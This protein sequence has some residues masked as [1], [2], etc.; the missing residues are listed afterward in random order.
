[1]QSLQ[2]SPP[3][4][5]LWSRGRRG[6]TLGLVL[7][8][9]MGALESL[10]VATIMPVVVREIGGRARKALVRPHFNSQPC[11]AARWAREEAAASSH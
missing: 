6:L 2:P 11:L 9:S 1:M 10:A 3:D 5:G 4:E 7:T 8:V